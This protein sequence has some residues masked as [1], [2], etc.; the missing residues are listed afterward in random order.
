M[1]SLE[2][3]VGS[4]GIGVVKGALATALVNVEGRISYLFD[5]VQNRVIFRIKPNVDDDT[6]RVGQIW[7][8][9]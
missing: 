9:G 1:R 5:L 8:L 7:V 2:Y 4:T 6:E 3:S